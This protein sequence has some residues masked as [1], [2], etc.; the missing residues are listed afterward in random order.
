MNCVDE[1]CHS[2]VIDDIELVVLELCVVLT[3]NDDIESLVHVLC[4]HCE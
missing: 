1:L 4:V 2:T 3:E